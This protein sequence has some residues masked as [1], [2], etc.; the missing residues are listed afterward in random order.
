MAASIVFFRNILYNVICGG[1]FMTIRESGEMYLE[2]VYILSQ[3]KKGI[4][5]MDV[6]DYMNFSRPSV[7]RGISLLKKHGLI[8][9]DESGLLYLTP[10]GEKRAE[11][12]F[13]RHKLLTEFLCRIGVSPDV[14]SEDACRMEHAISEETFIRLK[15]F[16]KK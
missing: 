16:L 9:S 6:A 13:S 8:Y 1:V 15:E 2:T 10:D 11:T 12:V 4:R 3:N 7:T 5:S 14:A